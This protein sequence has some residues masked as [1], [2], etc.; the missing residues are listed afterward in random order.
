MNASSTGSVKFGKTF[1]LI[2]RLLDHYGITIKNVDDYSNQL[3]LRPFFVAI[4]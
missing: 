2:A 1:N 4:K 3:R